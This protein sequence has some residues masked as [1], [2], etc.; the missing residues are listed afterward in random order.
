MTR[1]GAVALFLGDGRCD[2][3]GPRQRK[4]T[5]VEKVGG[6]HLSGETALASRG[7]D[8]AEAAL[9]DP[10]GEQPVL[11]GIALVHGFTIATRNIKDFDDCGIELI[12]PFA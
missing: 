4:E 5:P 3:D 8:A 10:P 2:D 7:A 6:V 12:N 11:A 9:F 1:A